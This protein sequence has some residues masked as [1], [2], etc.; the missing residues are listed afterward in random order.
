MIEY[1]YKLT[2]PSFVHFRPWSNQKLTKGRA[3]KFLNIC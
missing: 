2:N 1:L 3:L